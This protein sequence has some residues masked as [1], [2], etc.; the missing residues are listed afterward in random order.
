M[1]NKVG[2]ALSADHLHVCAC[3]Q[4]RQGAETVE[5]SSLLVIATSTEEKRLVNFSADF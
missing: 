5:G 2:E 4:Q 1:K 3:C